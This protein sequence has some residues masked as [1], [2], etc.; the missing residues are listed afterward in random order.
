ME[1][2]VH[3][4][5]A[6]LQLAGILHLPAM[7]SGER[8]PAFMELHGF[9]SN[10]D[11]TTSRTVAEL[12]ARCGQPA[13]CTSRITNVVEH[14]IRMVNERRHLET[15][16]AVTHN[17]RKPV[18]KLTLRSGRTVTATARV[19]RLCVSVNEVATPLPMV[20]AT[21]EPPPPGAPVAP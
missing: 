16:A 17:N 3:F 11:S 10:K 15:V 21:A 12:F 2:R 6:G 9:G 19:P 5:S 14:G 4:S 1:Q 8:R 20:C 7:K 13:S 18:L